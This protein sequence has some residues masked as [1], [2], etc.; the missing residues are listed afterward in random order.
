MIEVI[1]KCDFCGKRVLNKDVLRVHNVEGFGARDACPKCNEV[2]SKMY[3]KCARRY[4]EDCEKC[5]ED[6]GAWT[7]RF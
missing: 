7:Q 6:D 4:F 3:F 2:L 1:A 5:R